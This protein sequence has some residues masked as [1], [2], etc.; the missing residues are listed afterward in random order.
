[1]AASTNALTRGVKAHDTKAK[2]DQ[3]RSSGL[4]EGTHVDGVWVGETNRP[5]SEFQMSGQ[6]RPCTKQ[7]MQGILSNLDHMRPR[8]IM[9]YTG[10]NFSMFAMP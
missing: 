1:M 5:K 2:G 8:R 9:V 6:D 3:P 4:E 10:L 7:P